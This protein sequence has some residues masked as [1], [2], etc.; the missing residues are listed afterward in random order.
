MP[1]LETLVPIGINAIGN[2]I[3]GLFAGKDQAEA[4]RLLEESM[5][6]IDAV[7]APPDTAK[8]IILEKFRVAGLETPQLEQ[9]VD[10][11]VSKMG[12]YQ[13][14]PRLREAGTKALERM[15]KQSEEGLTAQDRLALRQ[16]QQEQER[17]TQGKLAQIKQEAQMRGMGGAGSELAAQ[18]SS[19]Q[20]GAERGLTS[21]MQVGSDASQRALQ[22]LSMGAGQAQSLRGADLATAQ[23]TRGAEDEFQRFRA[24]EAIARQRSNVGA[25]NLA[26]QRNLAAQQRALDLNVTSTNEERRRQREAQAADWTRALQYGKTRAEA[27]GG[28]A[29]QY[30]EQAAGTAQSWGNI[31]KGAT[32]IYGAATAPGPKKYDT[33][34]GEALYDPYTG[35]KYT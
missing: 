26:Q 9:A 24:Q 33:E 3:G 7:G 16:V 14:D 6:I 17:A 25:Q 29:K 22:A 30:G 31:A 34:T 15:M 32:D 1:L 27:R 21:A 23:A 5:S 18:L 10:V 12:Q 4:Q 19:A 8:E 35:K 2:L 13:E 20:A 11:G 28:M